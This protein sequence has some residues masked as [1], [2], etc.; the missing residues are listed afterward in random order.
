MERE[1]RELRET[2]EEREPKNEEEQASQK[3]RKPK[4]PPHLSLS[5]STS[6]SLSLSLSLSSSHSFF[7]LPFPSPLPS[8]ANQFPPIFSVLGESLQL[9]LCLANLLSIGRLSK[10]V[11][12]QPSTSL[13]NVFLNWLLLCS[14]PH[15]FVGDLVWPA[16][17]EN[18]DKAGVD[19]DLT[20]F[21]VRTVVLQVSAQK[22]SIDFTMV[23]KSIILLVLPMALDPKMFS[24][25]G[26]L[27]GASSDICIR[28]I[29]I[30]KNAAEIGKAVHLLQRLA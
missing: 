24:A 17:L 6:L 29:L 25:D 23:L 21:M 5:L 28:S 22:R 15:F 11:A 20:F 18:L 1:S 2:R 14:S 10:S 9:P 19:E 27:P 4:K 30:V 26:M 13:N 16:D 3:D 7:I 12:N 8:S